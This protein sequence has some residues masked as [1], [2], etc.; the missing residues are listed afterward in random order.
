MTKYDGSDG[1]KLQ[2]RDEAILRGLLDSRLMTIKHAASLHFEGSYEAAKKRLQKLEG[3]G[4]IAKRARK[5]Q[6]PAIYS[7]TRRGFLSLKDEGMLDP[8]L[9][10]GWAKLQDRL[11]VAEM[12]LKHELA[13]MDVKAALSPALAKVDGAEL[14]ELSV[15]PERHAFRVTEAIS[16]AKKL[17]GFRSL[18]SKPDGF[19]HVKERA[20]DGELVNQYFFLEVDRGTESLRRLVKKARHYSQ[21]YRNGGFAARHGCERRRFKLC[22]FRALMIFPSAER[23]NNVAEK[24]LAMKSPVR[25]MI[26][27]TTMKEILLNPLGAN[28]VRPADYLAA[29]R[30]TDF[31]PMSKKAK[32]PYRRTVER[33]TWIE[34]HEIKQ[35]LL[36]T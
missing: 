12:T 8:L 9:E 33:E 26:W 23:R 32:G 35:Q 2:P 34:A 7:M 4:L 13:V 11:R 1:F 28:W 25:T 21:Y 19:V 20:C 5:V 15:N 27:L 14:V 10:L 3:A 36:S 17:V 16:D 24:L 31:D 6:D 22:P 29:V 30:G 18:L